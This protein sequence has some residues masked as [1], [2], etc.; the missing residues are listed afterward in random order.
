VSEDALKFTT[1]LYPLGLLS[2]PKALCD[3][4]L[5]NAFPTTLPSS[6]CSII[7][8][9]IIVP[10]LVL[11]FSGEHRATKLGASELVLQLR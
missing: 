1:L 6:G 11:G 7:R 8:F 3:I 10:N 5:F 9:E 2:K 4:H